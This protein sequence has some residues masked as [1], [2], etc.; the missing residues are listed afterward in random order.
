MARF[1]EMSGVQ[2]ADNM[3]AA[4]KIVEEPLAVGRV[5]ELQTPALS[6][7]RGTMAPGEQCRMWQIQTEDGNWRALPEVL[8]RPVERHLA[9]HRHKLH[10]LQNQME[11]A[12]PEECKKK[13]KAAI[14]AVDGKK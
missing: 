11:L 6:E 12:D 14:L 1:N 5:P 3:A 10:E 2:L 13:A 4:R 8:V 7:A 9:R